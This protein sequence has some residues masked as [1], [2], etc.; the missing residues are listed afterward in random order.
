MMA[1]LRASLAVS[2]EATKECSA[3]LYSAVFR[4]SARCVKEP[5]CGR[6]ITS[7]KGTTQEQPR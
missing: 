6:R 1:V 4:G 5:R 7:H 2:F 3:S